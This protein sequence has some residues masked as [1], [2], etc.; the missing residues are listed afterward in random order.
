MTNLN[1]FAL[2]VYRRDMI[3]V[4]EPLP[5]DDI[6]AW[7]KNIKTFLLECVAA[8]EITW[9]EYLDPL[10]WDFAKIEKGLDNP[11]HPDTTPSEN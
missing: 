4:H 10:F 1:L 7:H 9:R 6:L 3:M 2:T 5:M 8:G 11:K